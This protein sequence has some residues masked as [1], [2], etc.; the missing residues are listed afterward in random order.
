MRENQSTYF[1]KKEERHSEGYQ[2][3]DRYGK[4]RKKVWI[5]FPEF[6]AE[7]GWEAINRI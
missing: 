2:D 5:F 6:S 7:E 3:D 1:S 4:A